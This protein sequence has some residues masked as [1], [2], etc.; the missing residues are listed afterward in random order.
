MDQPPNTKLR[1]YGSSFWRNSQISAMAF[2]AGA[3][4]MFFEL[5]L[6]QNITLTRH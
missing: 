4:I 2:K 3:L 1:M 6:I 5:G